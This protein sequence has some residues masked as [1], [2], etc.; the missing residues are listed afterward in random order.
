MLKNKVYLTILTAILINIYS[1][2]Y[3]LAQESAKID[4]KYPDYSYEFVGE[5]KFEGFNRKMF[6]FNSKVNKY[7]IKPVNK[8]WASIMPKYGMD[9]IQNAY[10]NIEFPIRATS[11]LLQKDFK[12]TGKELLKFITNSTIGLGGLYDPAKSIFKIETKDQG[13]EQVLSHYNV[14]KG[15][16]L[17]LPIVPPSNIRGY[18]G[19]ILDCPLNP[20]SYII[21]PVP[22]IAKAG[23]TINRT[24]YMQALIKSI[25]D[26]Y[27]DP[28]EITK[29]MYG[30]DQY[31]KN[32][33]IDEKQVHAEKVDVTT[34]IS[35]ENI[36]EKTIK[37]NVKAD[38]NL[39]GFN[40]QSPVIDSMRTAYFHTPEV[41]K[42]IW[43]EMSVWNRCFAN[44][45]KTDYVEVEKNRPEYKFRYILQKNKNAPLAI[46]YPS[47]G[48][49]VMSHHPIIF[50]KMFYDQGYS[51]V[52]LGSTFH[53]EFVKSMPEGYKPGLPANDAK[54]ARITT[55]K[56]LDYLKTK[57]EC[58][59]SKKILVGTSFGA[60][61]TL[62]AASQ[63][64]KENILGISNYISIN[65]PIELF[66][67]LM[68]MDK[69]CHDCIA[70]SEDIKTETAIAAQKVV[71]A[72]K[73]I[74]TQNNDSIHQSLNFSDNEA[75][76]IT[77]FL[78]KQK[79]SDLVFALE[80]A[81]PTKN[82]KDLYDQINNMTFYDYAKKY[83]G[84]DNY[85][86]N[87]DFYYAASLYPI[88]DFLQRSNNYKIYHSVDDYFVN[89][90]QLAWLKNLADKK[91]TFFS[92][93][94]HMG[95]MYRPEF[96][97]AFNKDINK[98]DTAQKVEPKPEKISSNVK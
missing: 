72:S 60:L 43:S 16:Y 53:W 14:K 61:T 52:I 6:V 85:N 38:I 65:P 32:S 79:L 92:N 83:L 3:S 81:S 84:M 51:I 93:G 41:N 68:Q 54:Y 63:E 24:T 45:I 28:Y 80:N 94:A 12:G 91:V 74:A 89:K 35:P 15:P 44:R 42:S 20:S 75:K 5:D 90:A 57:K 82:N 78:M 97:E 30:I 10:K 48:E 9:R 98:Q 56:I 73:E 55:A 95:F 33:N 66:F 31:I 29:K 71:K 27:A 21:G 58:E 87:D 39:E 18:V 47:I 37:E 22:L 34:L 49:G 96:I 4:Y 13:M 77:G 50:A 26:T 1:I 64:E 88:S 36:P 59:F 46:L 40:P 69:N 11:C 19:E 70:N 76:L 17:V 2:N 7:V 67:A 86:S 25:E 62:Y 8:V 23:F